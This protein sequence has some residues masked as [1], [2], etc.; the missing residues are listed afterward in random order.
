M[1]PSAQTGLFSALIVVATGLIQ[2]SEHFGGEG[3]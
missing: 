2:E 3:G 1:W